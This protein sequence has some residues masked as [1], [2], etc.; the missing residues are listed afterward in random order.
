MSGSFETLKGLDQQVKNTV[1]KCQILYSQGDDGSPEISP[2]CAFF[3][4]F[5]ACLIILLVQSTFCPR[6]LSIIFEFQYLQP[7]NAELIS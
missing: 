2:C 1:L 5:Q 4:S 3:S 7:E 6:R